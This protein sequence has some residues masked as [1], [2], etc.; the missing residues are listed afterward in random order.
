MFARLQRKL[1]IRTPISNGLDRGIRRARDASQ[2]R[3]QS[4]GLEDRFL[5]SA[6]F[7]S[8]YE[9]YMV[10]LINLARANPSAYASKLG[11]SLNEGLAAG[12]IS[13]AAKQP[14]VI[15]PYL[16][17]SAAKHSQWMLDTDRFSHTGA[18]GS[19][20]TQRMTA[21]GYVLQGG[22]SIG[23]NIAY[24]GT[25]GTVN[26]AS[27]VK[28]MEESLFVDARISGRGHRRNI[29][30]ETFTEVGVGIRTGK[31]SIYNAVMATQDFAHSGS[32]KFLTG[33]A[34]S[35]AVSA[36]KFYTPGEGLSSISIVATRDDNG[37]QFKTTTWASGGYRLELPPGKYSV[38]ASGAALGSSQFISSVTVGTQNVKVDFMRGTVR[39]APEIMVQ[40]GGVAI[41]NGDSTP[42]AAD[43]TEFGAVAV[44][45]PT[46]T[47]TYILANVGNATLN[48]TSSPQVIVSGANPSD[49]V[50][51]VQPVAS[52]AGNYST[53]FKIRFDPSAVGLRSAI[54]RIVSNDADE[55]VFTFSI[56]GT[57]YETAPSAPTA[58][59]SS[60]SGSAGLLSGGDSSGST[61]GAILSFVSRAPSAVNTSVQDLARV[62]SKNA[63]DY[64]DAIYRLSSTSNAAVLPALRTLVRE[65]WI[66]V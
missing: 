17:D 30:S 22:W 57:G 8:S 10:E 33:V 60:E 1:G 45:G 51:I 65:S 19:T 31:Y 29:L 6:V 62:G 18:N 41:V 47:K 13:T 2:D 48:L 66:H 24:R 39:V 7:P 61:G 36:D 11:I 49:F 15:N 28:T 14:L 64:L 25:T 32:A 35:D 37:Q 26:V 34:F 54:V 38:L 55:S 4:E 23:E 46:V 50:V 16:T 40:G 59:V 20:P 53:T 27:F 3:L 21:A 9:Q 52:I 58:V 63:F 44:E 5:L 42:S 43:A 12:T 56:A